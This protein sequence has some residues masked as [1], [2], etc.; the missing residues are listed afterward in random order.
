MYKFG[1]YKIEPEFNLIFEY[2]SG[3]IGIDD[4]IYIQ[5]SLSEKPIYRPTLN[6]ILDLRDATIRV[7][8]A[9]MKRY[10][11][12]VKGFPK[13][14]GRRLTAYLTITPNQVVAT[15]ILKSIVRQSDVPIEIGVFSTTRAILNWLNLSKIGNNEF[16]SIISELKTL[17]NILYN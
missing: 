16:V 10:V 4:F 13:V 14:F 9:D 7:D 12:F 5:L 17:P 11:E 3:E 2:Y 15:T 8:E 6:K 1:T